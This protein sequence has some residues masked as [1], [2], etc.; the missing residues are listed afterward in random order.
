MTALKPI[1]G[2]EVIPTESKTYPSNTVCA[3]PD[4]KE[5]VQLRPNGTPTVHHCFPRGLIHSD[6]YFVQILEVLGVGEVSEKPMP[7]PIPH[8]VGLCGSGTTGHHGDVEE[9][10]GW[11]KLEDGIWNWYARNSVFFDGSAD[12][13]DYH[14]PDGTPTDEEWTLIGPLNPQ[15][16]SREGRAKRAVHKG[17]AKRKRAN[18]QVKVPADQEDGAGVLDDGFANA[19][20]VVAAEEGLEALEERTQ[21]VC[22]D[23][24]F[25][26]VA[27]Q[28]GVQ[29]Q[30]E[31][32][33]DDIDQL[34]LTIEQLRE[35]IEGMEE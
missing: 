21:Y 12:G 6:S 4:C 25:V 30:L 5:K 35:E 16:G 23:A 14:R 2:V 11:I 28:A 32:A 18:W 8:A 13:G 33:I 19:Y 29:R 15:P 22:L 27:Q 31:K 7:E 3:H 1:E 24:V 10:R 9:H 34:E 26:W 20:R 17:E